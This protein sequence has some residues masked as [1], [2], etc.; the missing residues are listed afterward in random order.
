MGCC[1]VT[2]GRSLVVEVRNVYSISVETLSV[3]VHLGDIRVEKN[4]ILNWI[5]MREGLRA[6]AE[7][8]LIKIDPNM[9]FWTDVKIRRLGWAGHTGRLEDERIEKNS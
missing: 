5:L 2:S 6:W 1:R 8:G 9:I 7:Y 3:K 4:M